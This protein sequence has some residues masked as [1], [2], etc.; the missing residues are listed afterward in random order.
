MRVTRSLRPP[1]RRTALVS[2]AS[3]VVLACSAAIPAAA[4]PLGGN[5]EH[6]TARPAVKADAIAPVRGG[7]PNSALDRVAD[8]YGAYIDAVYGNHPR[9]AGVLRMDYLTHSLQ[10]QLAIWEQ[11]MH[12]DGVLR[13]QNVPLAWKVSYQ[14]S[15]MGH[16]W[17]VVTLTWGTGRHATT[18]RLAVQSDLATRLISGIKDYRTP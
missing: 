10:T 8:F 16:M 4:A 7:A 14:G 15:G 9:L 18:T 11:R 13:A 3:A 2:A 1:H 17:S 6:P 5:A 12:A